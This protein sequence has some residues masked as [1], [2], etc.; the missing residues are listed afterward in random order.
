MSY[1]AR[2]GAPHYLKPVA[3]LSMIAFDCRGRLGL[4]ECRDPFL[5]EQYVA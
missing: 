3:V 2:A 1:H 5:V 4:F